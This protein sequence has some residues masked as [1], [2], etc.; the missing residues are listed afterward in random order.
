MSCRNLKLGE[1]NSYIGTTIQSSDSVLDF[2]YVWRLRFLLERGQTN[3]VALP[4]LSRKKLVHRIA[5]IP[6]LFLIA[7]IPH[8]FSFNSSFSLIPTRSSQATF[9]SNQSS[10]CFASKL[11]LIPFSTTPSKTTVGVTCTPCIRFT[12]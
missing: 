11:E 1:D 8:N 6:F 12:I 3:D 10:H 9:F 7:I 2:D 4:P 5:I